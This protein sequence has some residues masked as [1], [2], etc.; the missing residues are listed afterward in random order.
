M[1]SGACRLTALHYGVGIPRRRRLSA[2]DLRMYCS[3]GFFRLPLQPARVDGCRD[4]SPT[5]A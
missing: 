3:I 5:F 4:F 2:T 1:A